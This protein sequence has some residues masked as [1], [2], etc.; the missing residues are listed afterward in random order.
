MDDR[1]GRFAT[2]E[3]G[4]GTSTGKIIK[5][6]GDYFTLDWGHVFHKSAFLYWSD[7]AKF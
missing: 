3:L 1:I 2:F 6:E 5:I 4:T 7:L